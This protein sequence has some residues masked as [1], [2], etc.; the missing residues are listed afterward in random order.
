MHSAATW[1]A[2]PQHAC[3]VSG[4][5][6]VVPCHHQELVVAD[7]DLLAAAYDILSGRGFPGAV[8]SATRQDCGRF[9]RQWSPHDR[10]QPSRRSI[11]RPT[12]PRRSGGWRCRWPQRYSV[13]GA[14]LAACIVDEPGLPYLCHQQEPAF[15][16]SPER[17]GCSRRLGGEQ[18]RSLAESPAVT[19][20]PRGF[21]HPE[22]MSR[23]QD[24]TEPV[25]NLI[26]ESG[27]Y[28]GD[29]P[30]RREGRRSR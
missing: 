2:R 23:F 11:G 5:N 14:S 24:G 27:Q 8:A 25:G 1:G 26:Q 19:P 6:E 12:S 3:F 29:K 21:F 4:G 30:Y 15:A 17:D 13:M 22:D 28:H 16:I 20:W 10:A 18:I 9:D 7:D